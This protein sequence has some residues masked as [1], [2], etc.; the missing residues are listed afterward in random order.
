MDNKCYA[1]FMSDMV[2][3]IEALLKCEGDA[4]AQHTPSGKQIHTV[5]QV[6]QELT[7]RRLPPPM[8]RRAPLS[9]QTFTAN[10]KVC[11]EKFS[12]TSLDDAYAKLQEHMKKFHPNERLP[13]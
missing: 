13:K 9:G 8:S 3:L 5:A 11:K 2:P 7:D 10:C 4:E 6:L 12:G 1:K